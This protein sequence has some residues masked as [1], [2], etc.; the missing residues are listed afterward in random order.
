VAGQIEE[1]PETNRNDTSLRNRR[2]VTVCVIDFPLR[3][4]KMT[5]NWEFRVFVGLF[6]SFIP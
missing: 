5:L 2:D 3:R 4:K 1:K 6:S